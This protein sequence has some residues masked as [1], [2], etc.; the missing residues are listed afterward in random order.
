MPGGPLNKTALG[1]TDL[2]LSPLVPL[3]IASYIYKPYLII[4][5]ILYDYRIKYHKCSPQDVAMVE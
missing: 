2:A 4:K 5:N 3:E 1:M